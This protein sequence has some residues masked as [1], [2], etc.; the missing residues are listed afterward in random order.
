MALGGAARAIPEGKDLAWPQGG[1]ET[2]TA[3]TGGQAREE[4][5]IPQAS[6]AWLLLQERE[7]GTR[8]RTET[9]A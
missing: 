6:W 5:R 2:G 8:G 3:G 7:V 9:I 4:G 1:T